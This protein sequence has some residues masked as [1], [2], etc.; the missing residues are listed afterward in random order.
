MPNVSVIIPVYNAESTIRRAIDSAIAQTF[1]STEIIVVDDGSTD[2]TWR[3]LAS[4]GPALK[5]VRQSN[6]GP[7]AAR[8]T[9]ERAS[10][11][12]YVAFLDAD[13]AWLPHKL[14]KMVAALE[15]EPGAVLAYSEYFA[16]DD[17]GRIGAVSQIGPPPSMEFMLTRGWEKVT[18]T[19]VMRRQGFRR[20]GGFCEKFCSAGLEDLWTWLLAREEGDFQYVPEPLVLYHQQ[21]GPGNEYRYLA[22]RSIFLHLLRARYGARSRGLQR[23]VNRFFAALFLSAALRERRLGH[24]RNALSAAARCLWY[25]PLRPLAALTEKRVAQRRIVEE[26]DTMARVRK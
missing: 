11:G 10:S 9:A 21:S 22:T 26:N 14:F 25:D 17:N 20:C 24:Y 6:R 8:N 18:S 15:R 13:D 19:V 1:D 7:A 4:Y 16:I 23:Q 5:L 3:I 12:E 2:S